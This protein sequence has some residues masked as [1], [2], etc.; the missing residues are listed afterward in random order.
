MASIDSTPLRKVLVWE[1]PVRILHWVHFTS[2]AVLVITGFYIAHP[3]LTVS[4]VQLNTTEANNYIMGTVRYIHFVF[5]F[6]FTISFAVRIY[7]FFMGNRYA[8]W[9]NW[10]PATPARIRGL[11]AQLKYYLFISRKHPEF[12]GPNPIAGTIYL[13]MG[14]L[15]LVQIFTG[16]AL[17]GLPFFAYGFWRT[18]FGWLYGWLG[19]GGL[20]VIHLVSLYLFLSFFVVHIYLVILSDLA[21]LPGQ[22]SSMFNGIKF[23]PVHRWVRRPTKPDAE[24]RPA[25]RTSSGVAVYPA[26]T[27]KTTGSS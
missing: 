9:Y 10:L 15:L 18:L 22:I 19:A 21:G 3:I 12:L 8:R 5:A 20:R 11:W 16:F 6:I 7:W 27:D 1:W 17:F 4:S 14:F 23:W 2:F 24:I 25:Q 26:P 13:L